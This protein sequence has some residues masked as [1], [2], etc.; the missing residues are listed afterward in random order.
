[1]LRS[2]YRW[3][4]L[5]SMIA[6]LA[7]PLALAPAAG[8]Q[9]NGSGSE[10]ETR[11]QTQIDQTVERIWWNRA[12]KVSTLG[13]RTE[14]RAAMDE[15]LRQHLEETYEAPN[16]LGPVQEMAN[17]LVAGDWQGA[18]AKAE[19]VVEVTANPVR[20]Q[21]GLMIE[22]MKLLDEGQRQT[23]AAEYPGLMKRPWVRMARMPQGRAGGGPRRQN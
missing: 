14:T 17:L 8:A 2:T 3:L 6:L 7:C 11:R 9:E 22:V 15:L 13:L 1:M 10:R 4:S 21:M 12:D 19:E 20:R 16:R 23:L 5:T 18:E